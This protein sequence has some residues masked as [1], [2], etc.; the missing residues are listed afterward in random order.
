[1]KKEI[2]DE[3]QFTYMNL[4][5]NNRLREKKNHVVYTVTNANGNENM[6]FSIIISIVS[7]S[8]ISRLFPITQE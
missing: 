4:Y 6:N 2:S 8:S 7:V 5:Q 1:M 3:I